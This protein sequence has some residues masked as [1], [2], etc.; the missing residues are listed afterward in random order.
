M[1][2]KLLRIHK[3]VHAD[4][5]SVTDTQKGHQTITMLMGDISFADAH[6][7]ATVTFCSHVASVDHVILTC[8]EF[9]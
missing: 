9:I 6:G 2:A 5:V 7:A 4:F 1:I 8:Q 3:T